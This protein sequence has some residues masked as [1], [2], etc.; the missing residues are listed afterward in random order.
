MENEQETRAQRILDWESGKTPGPWEIV[1]IPTNRC[2]QRCEMCWQRQAESEHGKVDYTQVSDERLMRL[3]DEA[4]DLGVREWV[5]TGGGEPL[6]RGELVMRLCGRIRELGMNGW[7]HTNG[8]RLSREWSEQFV[9]MGWAGLNFSLDGPTAEINDRIRSKGA[10]EC[11]TRAMRELS[12]LK[13]EYGAG[14]PEATVN[15]VLTNLN[16]DRL[17][18]I[19]RLAHDLGCEGGVFLSGL[20]VH[21]E[22]SAQFGLSAAQQKALPDYLDKGIKEAQGLGVRQNFADFLPMAPHAATTVHRATGRIFDAVCFDAW[23]SATIVS[24]GRVGPCCRFWDKDAD[25][26]QDKTLKEAWLGP[27]LQEV[28]R[29]LIARKDLPAYCAT[30]HSHVAVR[31]AEIRAQLRALEWSRW[32]SLGWPKRATLLAGRVRENLRE[33]GVKGTVRRALE[34]LRM[35]SS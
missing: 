10:F 7:M 22:S 23:L 20:T 33:R 13:R 30:C 24:D 29:Q 34:W 18:E 21:D 32:P 6:T 28:R 8:I 19:V 12:G 9:A 27:Y 31:T 2:N 17:D 35:R 25:S 16:C 11:V 5:V 3:V 4:A 14:S 15:T 26:I 1:L